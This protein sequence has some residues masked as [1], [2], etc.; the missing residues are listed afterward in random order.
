MIIDK[1]K[2]TWTAE[3]TEK[4]YSLTLKR[5]EILVKAREETHKRNLEN[6]IEEGTSTTFTG[7]DL[8]TGEAEEKTIKAVDTILFKENIEKYNEIQNEIDLLTKEVEER[9]K[10]NDVSV[11]LKD[12]M[13]IIDSFELSD[14][15]SYINEWLWKIARIEDLEKRDTD[16]TFRDPFIKEA[17]EKIEENYINCFSFFAS[18]LSL[19]V[20]GIYERDREAYKEIDIAL[21]KKISQWY[22]EPVEVGEELA[23][24]EKSLNVSTQYRKPA[25]YITSL[26]KV[27]H[28]IFNPENTFEDLAD[29]DVDVAPQSLKGKKSFLVT[30]GITP[31]P[32]IEGLENVSPFDM[33]IHNAVMSIAR[34]NP[35]GFF[36]AKQV[37][38]FILYGN[39]KANNNPSKKSIEGAKG[40]IE[41]MRHI[42]LKIDYTE[43]LKLN[44]KLPE[45]T[46]TRY[47]VK[48]YM[49]PA[50]EAVLKVN[51]Q[52]LKGYSLIDTLPLEEYGQAT[53]QIGSCEASMLYLPINMDAQKISIR[54]VLIDEITH[55]KNNKNW[56]RTITIDRLLRAGG[57]DPETIDRQ[58]KKKLVAFIKKALDSWKERKHITDYTINK[59]GKS[60]K[61]ITIKP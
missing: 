30:V 39:T 4:L 36:T 11:L 24:W 18:S 25:N 33:G 23:L 31:D 43:H 46:D 29:L 7:V 49:I 45:E 27:G 35:H 59:Q 26:T 2:E 3:E 21:K 5:N 51:G 14:F 20:E 55:M 52:E 53:D 48:N 12:A 50:K 32:N 16:I 44:K 10:K 60:N 42:D 56:N 37:A 6:N 13:E 28:T 34:E 58:K 41:L 40:S 15:R 61:S 1:L 54:N 17:K 8:K 9:Y 47:Y 19:Q 38:S 57:E 22:K